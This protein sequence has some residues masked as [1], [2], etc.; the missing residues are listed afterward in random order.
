MKKFF[1]HV[2]R[3]KTASDAATGQ[4]GAALAMQQRTVVA[5][6]K[7]RESTDNVDTA[8]ARKY[9]PAELANF[10]D[11]YNHYCGAVSDDEKGNYVYSK[12]SYQAVRYGAFLDM[13]AAS[14]SP[15]DITKIEDLEAMTMDVSHEQVKIEDLFIYKL[16]LAGFKKGSSSAELREKDIKKKFD[17]DFILAAKQLIA[18]DKSLEAAKQ[19]NVARAKQYFNSSFR[20]SPVNAAIQTAITEAANGS[21][22][23]DSKEL[24]STVERVTNEYGAE[25][26]RIQSSLED[27]IEENGVVTKDILSKIGDSR[28]KE[29]IERTLFAQADAETEI[30]YSR[31]NFLDKINE[32][33]IEI[34]E[35]IETSAVSP[36][37]ALQDHSCIGVTPAAALEAT[38]GLDSSELKDALIAFLQKQRLLPTDDKDKLKLVNGLFNIAD[39]NAA[40]A[41]LNKPNKD[42]AFLGKRAFWTEDNGEFTAEELDSLLATVAEKQRAGIEAKLLNNRHYVN[43]GSLKALDVLRMAIQGT[44]DTVRMQASL[45]MDH[46]IDSLETRGQTFTSFKE[47]YRDVMNSLRGLFLWDGKDDKAFGACIGRLVGKDKLTKYTPEMASRQTVAQENIMDRTNDVLAKIKRF[48]LELNTDVNKVDVGTEISRDLFIEKVRKGLEFILQGR[49]NFLLGAGGLAT[50]NAKT[51]GEMIKAITELCGKGEFAMH[52]QLI[53]DMM[54]GLESLENPTFSDREIFQAVVRRV[55]NTGI[56]NDANVYNIAIILQKAMIEGKY[57]EI[58][59]MTPMSIADVLMTPLTGDNP[60]SLGTGH[61]LFTATAPVYNSQGISLEIRDYALGKLKDVVANPQKNQA[62]QVVASPD[63]WAKGVV[64]EDHMTENVKSGEEY[65]VVT[66]GQVVLENDKPR[67][68]TNQYMIPPEGSEAKAVC[69]EEVKTGI[70]A[71][72]HDGHQSIAVRFAANTEYDPFKGVMIGSIDLAKARDQEIEYPAYEAELGV[73]RDS[74]S[75][76]VSNGIFSPIEDRSPKELMRNGQDTVTIFFPIE[77]FNAM[78]TDPLLYIGYL[79]SEAISANGEVVNYENFAVAGK[80]WGGEEEALTPKGPIKVH[81]ETAQAKTKSAKAMQAYLAMQKGQQ[82]GFIN[83]NILAWLDTSDEPELMPERLLANSD[84]LGISSSPIDLGGRRRVRIIKIEGTQ[85]GHRNVISGQHSVRYKKNDILAHKEA[86]HAKDI[87]DVQKA[88]NGD[89]YKDGTII[90]SQLREDMLH[91]SGSIGTF[92]SNPELHDQAGDGASIN[93]EAADVT[94]VSTIHRVVQH[95]DVENK[96]KYAK[97]IELSADQVFEFLNRKDGD[98]T[99]SELELEILQLSEDE[100]CTAVAIS[101]EIKPAEVAAKLSD[102]M[103]KLSTTRHNDTLSRFV[104]GDTLFVAAHTQKQLVRNSRGEAVLENPAKFS[105]G[106][107]LKGVKNRALEALL[108]SVHKAREDEFYNRNKNDVSK[109]NEQ[110]IL[111]VA[112]STSVFLVNFLKTL[113][114]VPFDTDADN[115]KTLNKKDFLREFVKLIDLLTRLRDKNGSIPFT[116]KIKFAYKASLRPDI[117]RQTEVMALVRKAGLSEGE[118][119]QAEAISLAKL[120]GFGAFEEKMVVAAAKDNEIEEKFKKFKE[121][122]QNTLQ[123]YLEHQVKAKTISD[124]EATRLAT[125]LAGEMIF[126]MRCTHLM[127]DN[128]D[129]EIEGSMYP[130]DNV[131]STERP[132]DGGR[133]ESEIMSDPD[134]YGQLRY[135]WLEMY[136]GKHLGGPRKDTETNF[137]GLSKMRLFDLDAFKEILQ[138]SIGIRD[139]FLEVQERIESKTTELE[140]AKEE[141]EKYADRIERLE[142]EASDLEEEW[143]RVLGG[144]TSYA[145]LQKALK[146]RTIHDFAFTNV[147]SYGDGGLL[148]GDTEHNITRLKA[149]GATFLVSSNLSH[150]QDTNLHSALANAVYNEEDHSKDTFI[151]HEMYLKP[152]GISVNAEDLIVTKEQIR[153]SERT[154]QN[155]IHGA[156]R[157]DVYASKNGLTL[158]QMKDEEFL[159]LSGKVRN[160]NRLKHFMVREGQAA[161]GNQ[162]DH[163]SINSPLNNVQYIPHPLSK[164]AAKLR[165]E[166]KKT[167]G[168]EAEIKEAE[169]KKYDVYSGLF[170]PV[171]K[172]DELLALERSLVD[173]GP[174]SRV[175]MHIEGASVGV[176]TPRIDPV[177]ANAILEEKEAELAALNE[178]PVTSQEAGVQQKITARKALLTAEIEFARA[179]KAAVDNEYAKEQAEA[180]IIAEEAKL[181]LAKRQKEDIDKQVDNVR[182]DISQDAITRERERENNA[183]IRASIVEENQRLDNILG[184]LEEHLKRERE[185]LEAKLDAEKEKH[186]K[187]KRED[188]THELAVALLNISMFNEDLEAAKKK[189]EEQFRESIEADKAILESRSKQVGLRETELEANEESVSKR[190]SDKLAQIEQ[191]QLEANGRLKQ[192]KTDTNEQIRIA[193]ESISRAD[194]QR[195]GLNSAVEAARQTAETAQAAFDQFIDSSA[196][197]ELRDLIEKDSPVNAGDSRLIASAAVTGTAL[198]GSDGINFDIDAS[199]SPVAA[200]AKR[201]L[202]GSMPSSISAAF[203]NLEL[204]DG[205]RGASLTFADTASNNG[206]AVSASGT[207]FDF[208]LLKMLGDKGNYRHNIMDTTLPVSSIRVM[209]GNPENAGQIFSNGTITANEWE[210]GLNGYLITGLKV[211][212]GADGK[213]S[214]ELIVSESNKASG[215]RSK[216]NLQDYFG[217]VALFD[218]FVSHTTIRNGT[219]DLMSSKGSLQL[220]KPEILMRLIDLREDFILRDLSA[221]RN[222][223][224]KRYRVE[225]PDDGVPS[226]VSDLDAF[227]LSQLENVGNREDY[228]RVRE[229]FG[230]LRDTLTR[231]SQGSQ[232]RR[233]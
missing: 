190:F 73:A 86:K 183:R 128:S 88:Y 85:M 123:R 90:D 206:K 16:I 6:A 134:S 9:D 130:L 148:S 65:R 162:R 108:T 113:K 89:S 200:R 170:V 127:D 208:S 210:N 83:T 188:D 30:E 213:H 219:P 150:S 70:E 19:I 214:V 61:R 204:E 207:T 159:V 87:A 154:G 64:L 4:Q 84:A 179:N 109:A 161:T 105:L 50:R 106:S 72:N 167:E 95:D 131:Y 63:E 67:L 216:A 92:N 82:G 8:Y 145:K 140:Q 55:R 112:K 45:A 36:M 46:I 52:Y 125:A 54:I 220:M 205:S 224:I 202:D 42:L 103:A 23:L 66:V 117:Q 20:G 15:Q 76:N 120:K 143:D 182:R 71:T 157:A 180:N 24:V 119:N 60:E 100:L 192:I 56:I 2:I 27:E 5:S 33:Y 40:S 221:I 138:D 226:N 149:T 166:G 144:N 203:Q 165:A 75:A 51:G 141:P 135:T 21:S 32:I 147:R 79:V 18:F 132:K 118:S 110:D 228:I 196:G 102:R 3:N 209:K 139:R 111:K 107:L 223:R 68:I 97:S 14:G 163:S 34:M 12:E 229:R 194:S 96:N 197:F 189:T 198:G 22:F 74:L 153:K 191:A 104:V 81:T 53:F 37:A 78:L 38:E 186:D 160:L 151:H 7:Q 168:K 126:D 225:N 193:R 59:G 156:E 176:M 227:L 31:E 25:L 101:P 173:I 231:P 80:N 217:Q 172:E 43:G 211:I 1:L 11:Y 35:E 187:A 201:Y 116:G 17:K 77:N 10:G 195:S 91:H 121:D 122:Y 41:K 44:P 171:K 212:K 129:I 26:V 181:D 69:I 185:T 48:G 136:S 114:Y 178:E 62:G 230:R 152:K 146:Q 215:A 98:D 39:L 218:A 175:T 199:E 93:G 137:I 133:T 164:K 222:A 124:E 58:E 177:R 233:F 169:A 94:S 49:V 28:F 158:A 155:V 57:I 115:L 99:L 13:I 29:R 174:N 47:D 232:R 184:N 142:R